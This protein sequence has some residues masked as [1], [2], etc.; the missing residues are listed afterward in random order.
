M[1]MNSCSPI[2]RV[3]SVLPLPEGAT[4]KFLPLLIFFLSAIAVS[5]QNS[6]AHTEP[7][8]QCADTSKRDSGDVLVI[9]TCNFKITVQA[10]TPEGTQP[11]RSLD[12]GGS[13]SIAGSAHSAWRIFACAWPGNPADET[14]KEVT[15]ATVKYACNAPA[16]SPQTQQAPPSAG[17]KADAVK[18]YA[19]AHPYMD[20]P[21]P[22]LKK[23]VHELGRLRL[24]PSQEQLSGI[25]DKVA[26]Q[27]D[28]LLHNVPDLISD[29]AVSQTQQTS[30][31]GV[32]PGCSGTGCFARGGNSI[33]DDKFNYLILTHPAPD[34]RLRLEEYRTNGNGKPI[35]QG[36]RT[37]NFQGFLS[38]WIIFCSLNQVESRFRYLGQQQT[39]G[40]NTFV[41]GFAQNA[42]LVESP[43]LLLREKESVPMILQGIA[44]ID[45]S[46]YRIVRL[47]TDLLAPQPEIGF[48][49]QTASILFGPVRI[50]T[51]DLALW[52]PQAVR[53][54][55]DGAGRLLQEE[56]KY[57]KYRL[58]QAKSRIIVSPQ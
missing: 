32:I 7:A 38:S 22:E 48:Q 6:A 52:L 40:H 58:Y 15:Y 3:V 4:R 50:P 36:S 16:A 21:L 55:M 31:Q 34:S 11:T 27:A 25:L 43:G 12:P 1:N 29:E 41:I 57:S 23:A 26:A 18:F 49:R 24:V 42:A 13:N 20:L 37:P 51:L 47:R 28:G 54:E 39:D 46:D 19:G 56:H 53:V 8:M 10:S 33:W 17:T 35:E 30:S 14:G 2:R 9:N 44:W 5:A 45:Q